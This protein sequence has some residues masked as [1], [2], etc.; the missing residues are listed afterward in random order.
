MDTV[1]EKI[2]QEIV[3]RLGVIRIVASPASGYYTDCGKAVHR[4]RTR[5]DPGSKT[6]PIGD[7]GDVPCIDVWP[8][9]EETA[10]IH[11]RDKNVMTVHIEGFHFF[12]AEAVT[13]GL[14]VVEEEASTV[15]ER[16]LGDLKK[17]LT[18]PAWDR[19]RPVAGSPVTYLPPLAESIR[20]KGGGTEEYPE[21]GDVSVAA[22][23]K[24]DVTY[25]TAIGDPCS[26]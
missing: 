12:G 8:L 17:C 16:I 4:A 5:I 2:I 19:R 1:R 3:T 26:Q 15:A 9:L 10:Q 13:R 25:Y 20:Y 14:A 21:E 18:T 6:D 22:V 7:P 11:G 23:A 24:F